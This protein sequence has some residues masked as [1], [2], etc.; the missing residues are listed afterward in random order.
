MAYDQAVMATVVEPLNF[1][2]VSLMTS[3]TS[4]R[5]HRR[6]SVSLPEGNGRIPTNVNYGRAARTTVS[7]HSAVQAI[8]VPSSGGACKSSVFNAYW[9]TDDAVSPQLLVPPPARSFRG[10]R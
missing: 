9:L 6:E 8:A 5:C 2:V 10:H 1:T 4:A 7:A 3:S